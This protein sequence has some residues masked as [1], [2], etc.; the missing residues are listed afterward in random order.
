MQYSNEDVTISAFKLER[1]HTRFERG[2]KR[3]LKLN[4]SNIKSNGFK[5]QEQWIVPNKLALQKHFRIRNTASIKAPRSKFQNEIF[6]LKIRYENFA[7]CSSL[8]FVLESEFLFFKRGCADGV[9]P[10]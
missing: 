1:S 7:L 5:H 2:K 10:L 4:C 3:F 8:K 6:H 9:G